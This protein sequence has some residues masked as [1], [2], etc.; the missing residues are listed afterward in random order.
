MAFNKSMKL[1]LL[2]AYVNIMLSVP[3]FPNYYTFAIDTIGFLTTMIASSLLIHFLNTRPVNQKNLLNRILAI[4]V[5][6]GLL[7]TVRNYVMAVVTCFFHSELQEFDNQFP[8]LTA[9]FLSMR[10]TG[11]MEAVIICCLSIG[12]LILF[13]TPVVFHNLNPTTGIIAVGFGVFAIPVV[14]AAYNWIT[15]Y[16]KVET[17]ISLIILNFQAEMGLSSYSRELSI[18]NTH[19]NVTEEEIKD[20]YICNPLPITPVVLLSTILLEIARLVT[21]LNMKRETLSRIN[22]AP[23]SAPHVSADAL[24]SSA[25]VFNPM[26]STHLPS[27]RAST[28]ASA[29][30]SN[31]TTSTHLPTHIASTST[32]AS[33]SYPTTSTH[34]PSNIAS[35]ST[36]ASVSYPTTSTHLPSHIASTS[37][38]A[39]VSYPTT[40]THLPSRITS[41]SASASVFY[42]TT[43]TYL[44]S[45]I[46]S[47]SA[48]ASVSYPTTST[49]LPSHIAS[50]SALAS[51]SYPPTST[52]RSSL[53]ASTSASSSV[54]YPTASTHLPSLIASAPATVSV[55]VPLTSTNLP[56]HIT[57]TSACIT[58]D[59]KF[60]PIASTCPSAVY[61][62]PSTCQG[63]VVGRAGNSVIIHIRPSNSVQ[64][65]TRFRRAESFPTRSSRNVQINQKRR[66]SLQ[67]TA[68]HISTRTKVSKTLANN[69][70][71]T[72][73]ILPRHNITLT[74]FR[75]VTKELFMR[76]SSIATGTA[77]LCLAITVANLVSIYST[78][79]IVVVARRF[80]QYC[81]IVLIACLDKDLIEYYM[82]KFE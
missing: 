24:V 2:V 4:G 44:P 47:T 69:T 23:V 51:V 38:S 26:T 34:L 52:H 11:L 65:R 59:T 57:S 28:S 8:A 49:H 54:S 15:C 33:V 63:N 37:A 12:R 21:V 5:L 77:L 79:F 36:S 50:T 80:C 66:N 10:I 9:S 64:R 68:R 45:L 25:S 27:L 78:V 53:I 62:N 29:S 75:E 6:I 41:T 32:S 18:N 76:T 39:S 1:T 70:P 42:P 73:P 7:G 3:P 72:Q 48:S 20:S 19:L 56:T 16:S 74:H 60:T 31:P 43:S 81:V 46:A 61:D 17:P 14:D 67:M 40:S 13:A 22:P 30:V 35:I 82:N 71:K 55:S 58:E